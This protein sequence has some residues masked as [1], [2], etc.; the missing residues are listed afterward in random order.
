MNRRSFLRL[1][2]G[3]TAA[4]VA[5]PLVS[6][7]AQP[8]AQPVFSYSTGSVKRNVFDI[9]STIDPSQTPLLSMIGNKGTYSIKDFP[10]GKWS[11][12]EDTSVPR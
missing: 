12:I 11:W 5:L 10:E 9:I 8:V 4:T 7:L 2:G 6:Q 3:A 1:L